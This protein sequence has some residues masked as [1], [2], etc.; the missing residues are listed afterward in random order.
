MKAAKKNERALSQTSRADTENP[1]NILIQ[2]CI[3]HL[4][5]YKHQITHFRAANDFER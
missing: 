5:S 4:K 3:F 2:P 1:Y